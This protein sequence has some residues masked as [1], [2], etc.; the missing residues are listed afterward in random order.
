ML[1][2]TC[3]TTCA[4]VYVFAI[5]NN[6]ILSSLIS[7]LRSDRSECA[8]GFAPGLGSNSTPADLRLSTLLRCDPA[9]YNLV[10]A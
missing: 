2:Q 6:S 8:V 9:G 3:N 1:R 5:Q 7:V 10:F 4:S